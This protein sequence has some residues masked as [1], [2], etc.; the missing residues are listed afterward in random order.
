MRRQLAAS[1][2]IASVETQVAHGVGDSASVTAQCGP[3]A[4][5]HGE[6]DAVGHAWQAMPSARR[7]V[8][9]AATTRPAAMEVSVLAGGA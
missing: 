1:A 8:T 4:G 7:V 9:G 3:G 2:L 6:R 5:Q